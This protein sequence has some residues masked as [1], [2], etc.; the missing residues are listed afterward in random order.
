[1]R[2]RERKESASLCKRHFWNKSKFSYTFQLLWI[3]LIP[4]GNLYKLNV[5]SRGH[6]RMPSSFLFRW[7]KFLKVFPVTSGLHYPTTLPPLAHIY[8]ATLPH[9]SSTYGKLAPPSLVHLRSVCAWMLVAQSCLT[10]CNPLD[11]SLPG[12]SVH[13][14]LQVRKVEWVAISSPNT[15][16]IF[17]YNLVLWKGHHKMPSTLDITSLL[18]KFQI[19]L[20][21][22][23]LQ[24]LWLL[25][26]LPEEFIRCEYSEIPEAIIS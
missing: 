16:G 11:Y 5:A 4:S 18:P 8:L 13:G 20:W 6:Y 25:E 1:M 7:I 9:L 23:Q 17:I 3:Q 22:P 15:W 19:N 10:L 26:K 21:G 24:V 12:S 2:T 14:I